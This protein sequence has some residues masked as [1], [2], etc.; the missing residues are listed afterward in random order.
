MVPGPS[1]RRLGSLVQADHVPGR[2]PEPRRDLLRVPADRLHERPAMRDDVLDGR[3]DA[4]HHDVDH[5]A[6]SAGGWPAEYPGPADRAHR[7]V[8]RRRAVAALANPP[9]EDL[10]V[11]FGGLADVERR[12]LDVA[13]LAVGRGGR[14]GPRPYAVSM[15]A[16]RRAP[17]RR[18]LTA[19]ARSARAA[20]TASDPRRAGWS[21]ARRPPPGPRPGGSRTRTDGARPRGRAATLA[22]AR[23][24]SRG[25]SARA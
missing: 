17:L 19:R 5:E 18:G 11:E 16:T 12:D 10:L 24:G 22:C 2:I 4:L 20:P 8:E 9:A 23:A 1:S 7:V 21:R 6:R 15:A 13:D 3:G 14:H 25:S